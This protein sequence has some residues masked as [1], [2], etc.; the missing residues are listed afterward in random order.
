MRRKVLQVAVASPRT[1]MGR[2]VT[3]IPVKTLATIMHELH[4]EWVDVLKVRWWSFS[5]C[6]VVNW[7]LVDDC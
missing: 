4:H 2:S 5:A 1:V 3:S 6:M 7:I